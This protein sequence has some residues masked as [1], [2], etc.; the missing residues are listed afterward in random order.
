MVHVV[1]PNLQEVAGHDPASFFGER[2]CNVVFKCL[3]KW[4]LAAVPGLRCIEFYIARLVLDQD[5]CLGN[6][7][8]E[9]LGR[10]LQLHRRLERDARHDILHA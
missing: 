5:T 7:R 1:D 4:C 6:P 3:L 10:V 8:V 2:T 9:K